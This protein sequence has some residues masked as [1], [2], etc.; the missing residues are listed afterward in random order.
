[1]LL[2]FVNCLLGLDR[3]VI[4]SFLPMGYWS[5]EVV[6]KSEFSLWTLLSSVQCIFGLCNPSLASS[7]FKR[8]N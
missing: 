6:E 8:S 2:E 3:I 4:L 5:L 1:M 7:Q